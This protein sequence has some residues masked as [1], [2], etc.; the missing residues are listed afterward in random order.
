MRRRRRKINRAVRGKICLEGCNGG[1]AAADSQRTAKSLAAAVARDAYNLDTEVIFGDMEMVRLLASCLADGEQK[2]SASKMQIIASTP[3]PS[4][5]K[6]RNSRKLLDLLSPIRT[7]DFGTLQATFERPSTAAAS[8]VVL[9]ASATDSHRVSAKES[10][11]EAPAAA[12]DAEHTVMS[13]TEATPI[14]K[15]SEMFS[16]INRTP[17]QQQV[18]VVF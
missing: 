8:A 2:K 1:V 17:L 6:R 10:V 13:T 12:G 14:K 16:R 5:K 15:L 9:V 11:V 3:A 4:F 18:C 7:S